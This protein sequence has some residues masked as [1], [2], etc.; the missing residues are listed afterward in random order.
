MTVA[1]SAEVPGGRL[2]QPTARARDDD[3]L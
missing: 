3:D 2:A 1:P